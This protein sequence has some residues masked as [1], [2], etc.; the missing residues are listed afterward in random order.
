M[1]GKGRGRKERKRKGMEKGEGESKT[2]LEKVTL[3]TELS[4]KRI[5]R[6]FLSQ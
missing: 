6:H 1:K 5:S 3:I 4:L 2:F